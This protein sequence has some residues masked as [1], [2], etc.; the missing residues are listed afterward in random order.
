MTNPCEIG[1]KCPHCVVSREGD[2]VCIHPYTIDNC[3]DKL[4]DLSDEIDCPLVDYPSPMY[5]LLDIYACFSHG[6]SPSEAYEAN[7]KII[8]RIK[9]REE[10]KREVKE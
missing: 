6:T 3:P 2:P 4:F 7:K 1:F 10:A 5:D 8:E 9:A